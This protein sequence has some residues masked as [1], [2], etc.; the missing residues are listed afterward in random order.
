MNIFTED[1]KINFALY[2][3]LSAVLILLATITWDTWIAEQEDFWMALTLQ[4]VPLLLLLP[5]LAKQYYRSYSWL[6]FLSLIYFTSYVI[7][8]YSSNQ[9]WHDWLGLSASIVI[10]SSAMFASRWLQ[11][12]FV[13]Q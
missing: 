4:V 3:C 2:L 10:F 6:C 8:V 9:Q 13:D 7:Q 12:Y 5:G 11:R 1:K